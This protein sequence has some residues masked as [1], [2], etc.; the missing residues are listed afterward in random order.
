[1]KKSILKQLIKEAL[2]ENQPVQEVEYTTKA[3]DIPDQIGKFFVT[4]KPKNEKDTIEDLVFES[5][6]FYFAN[7]IRGGLDFKNVIGIYKQKSDARK[8]ATDALK[9]FKDQLDELKSS[10]DEF[11]TNKE[12]LN[13]KKLAAKD[14][15]KRLR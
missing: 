7:Q 12:E 11:R 4:E 1:M 5:D 9:A 3:F 10:M 8:A 2:E 6:V 15:I 14:L 13:K